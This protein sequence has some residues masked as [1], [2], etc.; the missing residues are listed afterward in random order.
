MQHI[1]IGNIANDGTGDDLRVAFL[2]VNQNFSE[3]NSRIIGQVDAENLGIGQGIFYV[4]DDSV[5]QFKSLVAGNNVTLSSSANEITI[6]SAD[7]IS[8]IQFNADSGNLNFN[9][10]SSI[11][12]EGGENINTSFSGS[13]LTIDL[14][15]N[16]LVVKDASPTL[17]GNLD[18]D[19]K[20][21]T[22]ANIITAN[23]ITANNV[24]AGDYSGN[25]YGIDIRP[26][27]RLLFGADYGNI[28][29]EATSGIDIFIATIS[30]DYG[31]ITSPSGLNSDYG[32]FLNPA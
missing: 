3:L 8:S 10:L 23:N 13:V 19:G 30:V 29:T 27:S 14:E 5:L 16:N 20:D 1:N 24:S 11:N 28:V 32:T 17:G 21:I 6:S 26:V 15:S 12:I 31:S 18:A 2:K 9:G 22:D 4:K 7:A 25:V